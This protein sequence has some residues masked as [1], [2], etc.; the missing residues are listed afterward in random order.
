MLLG[1][2]LGVGIGVWAFGAI[3]I[4]GAWCQDCWRKV[5]LFIFVIGMIALILAFI[6]GF[7]LFAVL[8]FS[9]LSLILETSSYTCGAT[10]FFNVFNMYHHV[11]QT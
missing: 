5:C 8:Y 3:G 2:G 9:K 1:V 10:P 11:L 6:A 4:I 7:I